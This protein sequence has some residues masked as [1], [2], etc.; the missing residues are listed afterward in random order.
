MSMGNT[1]LGVRTW[2]H[3]ANMQPMPVPFEGGA[4]Y[5]L[6]CVQFIRDRGKRIEK[7]SKMTLL[8]QCEYYRRLGYF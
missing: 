2:R 6:H 7:V 1:N 5:R 8:G 4:S 3:L